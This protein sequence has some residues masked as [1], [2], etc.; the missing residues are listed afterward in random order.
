[1]FIP[2]K[3]I[4]GFALSMAD[5]GL[6]K[7]SLTAGIFNL[8]GVP[9]FFSESY[10]SSAS[11]SESTAHSLLLKETRTQYEASDFRPSEGNQ[12]VANVY[13]VSKVA[14]GEVVLVDSVEA[15]ELTPMIESTSYEIPESYVAEIAIKEGS[16]RTR[17]RFA[18]T[19]KISAAMEEAEKIA[20]N[21]DMI[22]T[23]LV[24]IRETQNTL[25]GDKDMFLETLGSGI[26]D[27]QVGGEP[28]VQL[29][30]PGKLS[31]LFPRGISGVLN[32]SG[33]AL[34]I[35]WEGKAM[36]YQVDRRFNELTDGRVRS[37]ELTEVRAAD[38]AEYPA[39]FAIKPD[40][41]QYNT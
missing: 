39:G 37:L 30:F 2:K 13:T 22:F 20:G 28:Y 26:Y 23:G 12:I 1:M 40:Y 33:H 34:T 27:P 18:Y 17:V 36:R 25:S 16:I 10:S 5:S 41:M 35:E 38:A 29:N 15:T 6:V 24:V 32:K 14:K 4:N 7:T 9:I 11:P 31:L 19:N 8:V 21:Y 3:G